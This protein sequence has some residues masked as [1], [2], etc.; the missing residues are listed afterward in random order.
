M[1]MFQRVLGLPFPCSVATQKL[2]LHY[3]Y[4]CKDNLDLRALTHL[5][6]PDT[7]RSMTVA[8]QSAACLPEPAWEA[9]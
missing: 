8:L 3:S 2:R 5:T 7:D 6:R 4:A 9:A 1:A